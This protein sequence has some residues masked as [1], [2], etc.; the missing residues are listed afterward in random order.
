MRKREPGARAEASRL[1]LRRARGFF[2]RSQCADGSE[3][4]ESEN[5]VALEIAPSGRGDGVELRDF[6]IEEERDPGVVPAGMQRPT[7]ASGGAEFD[8]VGG[9]RAAR[10]EEPVAE[11][12]GVIDE[13][14]NWRGGDG[15][16]GKPEGRRTEARRSPPAARRNSVNAMPD[17][18]MNAMIQP[19]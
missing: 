1:K 2:R 17:H 18:A 6:E 15:D 13:P 12:D 10:E 9:V 14:E 5:R 4:S 3:R 19:S 11:A 8:G 7:G 16:G